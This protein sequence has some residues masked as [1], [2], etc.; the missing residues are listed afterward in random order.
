VHEA[1]GHVQTY[2]DILISTDATVSK[3]KKKSV[4][5]GNANP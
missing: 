1:E 3:H 2:S 5:A 4:A